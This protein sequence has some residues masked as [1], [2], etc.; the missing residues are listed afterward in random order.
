[1]PRRRPAKIGRQRRDDFLEHLREG[2]TVSAAA[3]KAGHD[4]RRFYELRNTDA[5]FAQE[6]EDAYE[7]G[8][9]ALEDE[10]RRRAVDGWD[11]AVYQ[12]GELAGTVRKYDSKLLELLLRARRPERFREHYTVEH[13]SL[14]EVSVDDIEKMSD[15][16]LAQVEAE[17]AKRYPN[18]RPELRLVEGGKA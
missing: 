12:K 15:E 18:L 1:M 4:R 11:E 10:A 16:E 8:T 17:I 13:K 2:L 6:W 3:E 7:Q 5:A 14:K 9:D